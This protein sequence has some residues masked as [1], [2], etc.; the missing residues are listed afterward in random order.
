MG[1]P[2]QTTKRALK[3]G[4]GKSV[5]DKLGH[6]VCQYGCVGAPWLCLAA[7]PPLTSELLLSVC[8]WRYLSRDH[9][10]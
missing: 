2:T 4:A 10:L 7:N 8:G 1:F 6:T 5:A 3:K 9:A